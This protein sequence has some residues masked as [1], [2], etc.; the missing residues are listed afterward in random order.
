MP[1]LLK[2]NIQH[3][4]SQVILK[5]FSRLSKMPTAD[6]VTNS[7]MQNV[8]CKISTSN[9]EPRRILTAADLISRLGSIL[10]FVLIIRLLTV[11]VMDLHSG[12]S[13][14]RICLKILMPQFSKNL[15]RILT[16][17][18]QLSKLIDRLSELS[19]IHIHL[20]LLKMLIYLRILTDLTIS[21]INTAFRSLGIL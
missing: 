5:D 14:T 8:L 2:I 12:L 10:P 21:K 4:L 9:I 18:S 20:S 15:S 3:L 13:I 7:I 17:R 11:L 1:K 6:L 19:R 16:L